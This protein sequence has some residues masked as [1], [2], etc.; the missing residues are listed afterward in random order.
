MRVCL[1]VLWGHL[2]GK[3]WPLASRLW[4][5]TV[6]WSLSHSY[7]GSG[8]VL[9]CIDSWSLHPYLFCYF[10]NLVCIGWLRFFLVFLIHE[11]SLLL[12][13]LANVFCCSINCISFSNLTD[14]FRCSTNFTSRTWPVCSTNSTSCN[15]V[16]MLCCPSNSNTCKVTDLFFCSFPDVTWRIHSFGKVRHI[17]KIESWL[18]YM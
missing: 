6:S 11:Y 13:S 17:S 16:D 3:G 18:G 5:V 10:V 4:C 14:F 1:Y 7:P 8:V 2:L 9:D 15:L 12:C